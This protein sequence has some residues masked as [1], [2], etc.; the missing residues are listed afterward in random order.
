MGNNKQKQTQSHLKL[1]TVFF[2][3]S[4]FCFFQFFS[5]LRKSPRSRRS[6]MNFKPVVLLLAMVALAAETNANAVNVKKLL[7]DGNWADTLSTYLEKMEK[8]ADALSTYLEK[9]EKRLNELESKP[10]FRCEWGW[11][12][13]SKEK[14]K[15]TYT[16]AFTEAPTF[17]AA[18]GQVESVYA[19]ARVYVSISYE[20]NGVT[21]TVIRR[22][23]NGS[24]YFSWMAC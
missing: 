4:F 16:R 11:D 3:F 15:I 24:G 6:K 9:M 23:I 21:A 12:W 5:V 1:P 20:R 17:L 22:E 19:S 10:Q 8:R 2:F 18:L 13:I 7:T 14:V